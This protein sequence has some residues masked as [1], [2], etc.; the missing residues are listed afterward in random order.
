[1]AKL[2][3]TNERDVTKARAYLKME[4]GLRIYAASL[5]GIHRSSSVPQQHAVEAAICDDGL[6]FCFK[7][8]PSNGCLLSD[9]REA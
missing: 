8:H 6:Q 5:A 3:K 2:N 9:V 1:M 4:G 7:R